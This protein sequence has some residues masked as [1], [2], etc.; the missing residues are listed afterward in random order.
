MFRGWVWWSNN[1]QVLLRSGKFFR[2]IL[3]WLLIFQVTEPMLGDV[4][5]HSSQY[6][7]LSLYHVILPLKM[8]RTI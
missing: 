6:L 3:E 7:G 2:V 8:Y 5:E 4:S 1:V